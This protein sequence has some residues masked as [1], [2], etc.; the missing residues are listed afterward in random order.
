[1]SGGFQ[2][3]HFL[4]RL[5][6]TVA[7]IFSTYNPSGLSAYHWIKADIY[8]D[9]MLKVLIVIFLIIVYAFVA[10]VVYSMIEVPGLVVGAIMVVLT[11]LE[12]RHQIGAG[13]AGS[14]ATQ[15]IALSTVSVYLAGMLSFPHVV[16]RLTGQT[17]KRYLSGKN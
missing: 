11:I 3:Q 17:Q 12:I 5:A 4:V 2:F 13:A 8:D 15:L 10:R 6:L 14:D 16:G 1:M 7:L 9:T